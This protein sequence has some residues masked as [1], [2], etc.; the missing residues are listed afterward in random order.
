MTEGSGAEPEAG[1]GAAAGLTLAVLFLSV[2]SA[3]PLVVLPLALLLLA[4]PAERRGKQ[5]ALGVLLAVAVLAL[6]GGVMGDVSRG[7]A[8]GVG[9]G[10]VLLTM[11]RPGWSVFARASVAVAAMLAIGLA[12]LVLS[13]RAAALDASVREHFSAAAAMALESF[14]ARAAEGA[15]A[16]QWQEAM[17]RVATVQ[18]TLF[19]GVLALESLAAVGLAS[20]WAARIRGGDP[21]LRLRP[22][23]EFRFDDQ[24]VW[25]LIAGLVLVVAP[26]GAIVA[27]A[28]YNLLFVMGG[29]YAVRGIGILLFLAGGSPSI[30]MIAFALLV[31]IFLY[32]IAVTTTVLVGLADTWLDVR[33]RAAQAPRA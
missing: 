20:W 8:L 28:G 23:R 24:L 4:L 2:F 21:L 17:E 30:L 10:F 33:G 27:R 19:P 26:L 12:A 13:G 7:W 6:P 32:P 31:G 16:S 14:G 9:G 11:L 18:W 22:L 29:L 25:V 15:V 1:W 5:A 3:L